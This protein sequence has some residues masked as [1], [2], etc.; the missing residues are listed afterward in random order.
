VCFSMRNYF[1]DVEYRRDILSKWNNL[2][3]K[4]V[5]I[6]S[7]N[8]SKFI[9]ECLQ[10]LIKDL[11]HLQHDLN[12]KLRSEKFI[13]N[14]LINACQNVFVCQ[15]VCFK[16]S[17]SL[18]DLINDLRS[19][20]VIYQKVNS[21]NFIETFFTDRR[22][23]KNFSFRI[24]QNR[25]YLSKKKCFVCQKEECWS[26]KHS[27]DER[28]T[29]KQK[30][31]N[32]FFIRIDHYISEYERTNSSS[33]YSEEDDYDT[34]LIDEMKTLIVNLSSLS[35]LSLF[36]N[37]NNLSNAETFMISFDFVQNAEMM[38]TN[39]ANRSLSHY[40]INNLHICMNDDQTSDVFQTDFK[41]FSLFDFFV[42]VHI[43]MKNITIKNID[44]FTYIII[45]RYTSEMFYDIMIDSKA[46]VRSIVDYE[47]YLAFIK[48]IFIDLDH[49]KTEAVNVQFEIESIFS[50]ESIIIDISIE[51]MK[52]HVIK[53]NT[54]FL[55][56]LAD[57]NCLKVYFNN[58]ENTLFMITK[59]RDLSM[60]RR[61]DHDFL[62]WKNSYFLHSYITQSFNSYFC[63]LTDIELRS[64]A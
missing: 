15:Y 38:I 35:S 16:L 62:L 37:S 36:S 4:S 64:I 45:D 47:Q 10:L 39:L 57:M 6:R 32:R 3:L 44:F 27:K 9:E 21:A 25:R 18:I 30:F 1:E 13:H 49:T 19:S 41:T 43:C 2:I 34:D 42:L 22:Y 26:T 8:E 59:N 12:S 14:K 31:K 61:F 28:E 29:T 63:Y 7:R 17:D 33:S 5:M 58:V 11:R 53:T 50:L 40:L 52:F 46:S 23:H 51:L 48:N 20:I 54:S 60:I 55:L 24:N 56:S